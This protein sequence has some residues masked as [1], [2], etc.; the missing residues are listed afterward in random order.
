MAARMEEM[1]NTKKSFVGKPKEK[2]PIGGRKK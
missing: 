2:R 1:K